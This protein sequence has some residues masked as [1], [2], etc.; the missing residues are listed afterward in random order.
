M[1]EWYLF[2]TQFSAIVCW[3]NEE[4]TEITKIIEV[5]CENATIKGTLS[6]IE[7]K[8]KK[9]F[10]VNQEITKERTNKSTTDEPSDQQP[11]D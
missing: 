9:K 1:V 6:R 10:V 8:T 4:L 7:V 2:L 3:G 5:T 11:A